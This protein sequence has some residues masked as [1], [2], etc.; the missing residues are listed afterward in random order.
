MCFFA[1]QY[2]CLHVR[3]DYCS[4]M[5]FE[6][7]HALDVMF[8]FAAR[9]CFFDFRRLIARLPFVCVVFPV[10]AANKHFFF[11]PSP[12]SRG[13]SD[14]FQ[15]FFQRFMWNIVVFSMIYCLFTVCFYGILGDILWFLLPC[16]SDSCVLTHGF[17]RLAR[18]LSTIG[19]CWGSMSWHN[20]LAIL[21]RAFMCCPS[22]F[23]T[24]GV[25][26]LF[27]CGKCFCAREWVLVGRRGAV[28]VGQF[29]VVIARESGACFSGMIFLLP[30]RLFGRMV[31]RVSGRGGSACFTGSFGLFSWFFSIRLHFPL[32]SA[33]QMLAVFISSG[34]YHLR[35]GFFQRRC[36]SG[37]RFFCLNT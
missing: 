2:R 3:R 25:C 10:L 27:Q 16:F 9:H 26:A 14:V 4:F 23:N 36:V 37:L 13:C 5:V 21:S 24:R 15:L 6:G 22:F 18:R 7:W 17:M 31:G 8:F 32:L 1:A 35:T 34:S 29:R 20:F 33:L 11:D 19:I 30:F 28:T 12:M